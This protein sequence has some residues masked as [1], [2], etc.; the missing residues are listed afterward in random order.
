MNA[1]R[2]L[3]TEIPVKRPSFNEWA[4]M[5]RKETNKKYKINEG[6]KKG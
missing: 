2:T 1:I 3:T 5:I 6:T 4:V